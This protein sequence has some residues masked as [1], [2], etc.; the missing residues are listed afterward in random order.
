MD[1]ERVWAV[2]DCRDVSG[3]LERLLLGPYLGVA[4]TGLV[5]T[6]RP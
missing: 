3:K 4:P 2:E 6:W 1:V 5:S